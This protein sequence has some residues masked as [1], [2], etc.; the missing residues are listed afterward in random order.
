MTEVAIEIDVRRMAASIASQIHDANKAEWLKAIEEL[1]TK[2]AHERREKEFWMGEYRA[3]EN[4][5][6]MMIDCVKK[7][8]FH[9]FLTW[10]ILISVA[11][12]VGIPLAVGRG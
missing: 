6:D 9:A 10:T 1:Q 7:W 2:V 5:L 11:L 8:R 4:D 12:G 3:T